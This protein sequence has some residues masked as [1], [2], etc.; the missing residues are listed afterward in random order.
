[1][2][3]HPDS[4]YR[5]AWL[6]LCNVFGEREQQEELDLMDSVLLGVVA[7]YDERVAALTLMIASRNRL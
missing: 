2:A 4:V 3:K 6:E 1:M 5:E 7:D